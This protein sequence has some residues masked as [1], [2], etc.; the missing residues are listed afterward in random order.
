MASLFRE[1]GDER[2]A[3]LEETPDEQ[4]ALPLGEGSETHRE[5]HRKAL[6]RQGLANDNIEIP[7]I[8]G[9][10]MSSR[11]VRVRVKR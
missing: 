5:A 9:R 1:H 4:G 3:E 6:A 11:R 8:A 7:E 2:I 10:A